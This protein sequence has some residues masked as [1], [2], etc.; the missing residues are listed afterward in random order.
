M[1]RK[2]VSQLTINAQSTE[3][4]LDGPQEVASIVSFSAKSFIR[5]QETPQNSALIRQQ[6]CFT[7]LVALV[8]F[9]GVPAGTALPG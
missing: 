9:A 1:P 2:R 5:Q 8:S 7:A 3:L 4:F 6:F